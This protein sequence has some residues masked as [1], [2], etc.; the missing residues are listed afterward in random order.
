MNKIFL[1]SFSG[2][3]SANLKSKI[4]N[5]KWLVLATILL[6]TIS[7]AE[8]QKAAKIP[9]IGFLSSAAQP[10]EEA[11]RQGL[12]ELGYVD[13]KNIIIEYRYGNS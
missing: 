9:R 2:S 7:I 13:G 12:R 4:Q 5:L 10:Q 1:I 3:R 6:A 8:A 11:F